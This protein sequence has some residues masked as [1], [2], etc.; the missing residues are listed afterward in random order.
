[1]LSESPGSAAQVHQNLPTPEHKN[2]SIIKVQKSLNLNPSTSRNIIIF[3]PI[4]VRKLEGHQIFSRSHNECISGWPESL[5]VSGSKDSF[6][7]YTALPPLAEKGS[8][9][10]DLTVFL[11][12][13]QFKFNFVLASK[14]L[15]QTLARWAI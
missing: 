13:C 10:W 11:G 8:C 12:F 15:R 7:S 2:T 6:K 1:M 5:D 14:V 3:T 9:L 4:P